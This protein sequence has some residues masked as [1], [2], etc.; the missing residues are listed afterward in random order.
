MAHYG[1]TWR[2]LENRK[3]ITL[4]CR[5]RRTNHQPEV[6]ALKISWSLDVSFFRYASGQTYRERQTHRHAHRNTSHSPPRGGRV[7][8]DVNCTVVY[9]GDVVDCCSSF[10]QVAGCWRQ[11]TYWRWRIATSMSWMWSFHRSSSSPSPSTSYS[12]SSSLYAAVF[13]HRSSII[14]YRLSIIGHW[15]SII[16]RCSSIIAAQKAKIHRWVN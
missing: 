2:H 4:Y 13:R 10:R 14:D 3:D 6:H 15:S 12:T 5:Q 9:A 8:V 16:D 11:P 1:Q 7:T